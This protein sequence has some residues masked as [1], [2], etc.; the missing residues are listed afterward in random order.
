M[1]RI[2]VMT[3][4]ETNTKKLDIAVNTLVN[5]ITIQDTLIDIK[6]SIISENYGIDD[7]GMN[8]SAMVIWYGDED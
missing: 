1:K 2:H 3:F 4:S 5:Q 6:F 7:M 8:Y